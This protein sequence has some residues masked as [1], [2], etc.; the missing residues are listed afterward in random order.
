MIA[1]RRQQLVRPR[2]ANTGDI[3]QAVF[4]RPSLILQ[5]LADLRQTGLADERPRAVTT[6]LGLHESAGKCRPG[7]VIADGDACSRHIQLD[8]PPI[9]PIPPG[10]RANGVLAHGPIGVTTLHGFRADHFRRIPGHKQTHGLVQSREIAGTVQ[11]IE[12]CEH[13]AH[14][15]DL[16]S[17]R[18]PPSPS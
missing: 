2:T 11:L 12:S 3:R 14:L 8:L 18:S 5:H 9:P 13:R 16:V 4:K 10:D 17:H 1:Q 15:I 7:A 6:T